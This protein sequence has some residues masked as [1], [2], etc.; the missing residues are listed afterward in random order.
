[1]KCCDIN[2]SMLNHKV[3]LEVEVLVEDGQG[4]FTSSWTADPSTPVFAAIQALQG[5]ER[6][7]GERIVFFARYLLTIRFR[8]DANGA[9]YYQPAK[10]RVKFQGK[11]YNMVSCIDK[12]M[13][14][15]Y[16]DIVV[17]EGS[18]P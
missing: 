5:T 9:P 16:L 12:D 10:T 14:G 6:Y 2:S 4:G 7:V 15:W 17:E 13:E 1:M 11:T 3:T 8:G 18:Q